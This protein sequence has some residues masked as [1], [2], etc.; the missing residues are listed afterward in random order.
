MRSLKIILLL[1]IWYL[2]IFPYSLSAELSTA[3]LEI[4]RIAYMN[5]Y[6]NAIQA[7]LNTIKVL[8]QN[9]AKLEQYS[10]IAVNRYMSKVALLNKEPERGVNEKKAVYVGSNSLKL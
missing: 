9:Q 3:Q 10:Q 2:V 7:D 6:A 8:K 4:I 1:I 5:G